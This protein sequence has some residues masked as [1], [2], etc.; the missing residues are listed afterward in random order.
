MVEGLAE[1]RE[2]FDF[3]GI[4]RWMGTCYEVCMRFKLS[5]GRTERA[6]EFISAMKD[7][8]SRKSAM[9]PPQVES[10]LGAVG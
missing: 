10:Q 1:R 3:G 5:A 8:T 4:A 7:M 6:F 2:K 9:R